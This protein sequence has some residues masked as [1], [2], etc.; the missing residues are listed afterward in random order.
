MIPYAANKRI[1]WLQHIQSEER[2]C[3]NDIK[4]YE[5]SC[6]AANT[7]PYF[8]QKFSTSFS[9]FVSF[10]W[11]M[12]IDVLGIFHWWLLL[13]LSTDCNAAF[14]F[15]RMRMWSRRQMPLLTDGYVPPTSSAT[16]C[17]SVSTSAF[18]SFICTV[19]LHLQINFRCHSVRW[20]VQG[21]VKVSQLK[22]ECESFNYVCRFIYYIF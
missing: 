9:V 13:S 12:A 17:Y 10:L 11:C 19:L 15:C 7:L 16:F 5:Q 3:M 6:I 20:H 2:S 22:C 4:A 1:V 21:P 8:F 18:K 14:A